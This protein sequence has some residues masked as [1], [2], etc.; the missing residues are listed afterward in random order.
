MNK[1]IC[2]THFVNQ[3]KNAS[4]SMA[5]VNACQSKTTPPTDNDYVASTTGFFYLFFFIIINIYCCSNMIRTQ[6]I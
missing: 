2:Y 5:S 3:K 1:L 6:N 4:R